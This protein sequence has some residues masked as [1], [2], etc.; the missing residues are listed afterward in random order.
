MHAKVLN[1]AVIY[2]LIVIIIHRP[3]KRLGTNSW[4]VIYSEIPEN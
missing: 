1:I 2:Y 4:I 3:Q